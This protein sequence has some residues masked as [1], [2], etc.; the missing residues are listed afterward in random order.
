MHAYDRRL[1]RDGKCQVA[2]SGPTEDPREPH[3]YAYSSRV[4][5]KAGKA[6]EDRRASG[7]SL[8]ADWLHY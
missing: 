7:I 4:S 2:A 3:A 1:G 8:P 5:A 6:S